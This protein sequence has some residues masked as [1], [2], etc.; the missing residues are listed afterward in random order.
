MWKILVALV[1]TVPRH[2]SGH[3]RQNACQRFILKRFAGRKKQRR[4]QKNLLEIC[5][6]YVKGK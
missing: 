5:S 4:E 3:R 6:K 1:E 2:S